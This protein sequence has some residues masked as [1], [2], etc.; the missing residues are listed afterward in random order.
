MT[1]GGRDYATMYMKFMGAALVGVLLY[2][3]TGWAP[4]TYPWLAGVFVAC[5]AI[6]AGL[7]QGLFTAVRDLRNDRRPLGLGGWVSVIVFTVVVVM[8]ITLFVMVAMQGDT[9]R[10]VSGFRSDIQC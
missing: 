8:A 9:E 1:T 6:P 10:C 3:V 4:L 7:A 2:F 5:L